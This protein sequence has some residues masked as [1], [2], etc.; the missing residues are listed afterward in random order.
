MKKKQTGVRITYL[1]ES[2][3]QDLKFISENFKMNYASILKP[4]IIKA[5]RKLKH[6]LQ[7][8]TVED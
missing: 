1:P 5:I 8:R 3:M 6:D 4:Y 7:N 2:D